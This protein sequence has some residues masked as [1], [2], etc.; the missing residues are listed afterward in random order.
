MMNNETDKSPWISLTTWKPVKICFL[1]EWKLQKWEWFSEL[2]YSNK[3]WYSFCQ[4]ESCFLCKLKWWNISEKKKFVLTAAYDYEKKKT[5]MIKLSYTQY[6]ELYQ[7]VVKKK[8][9][10]DEYV[11]E[12][13]NWPLVRDA[14]WNLEK[15]EYWEYFR[16]AWSWPRPR[17]RYVRKNELF[18]F[19]DFVITSNSDHWKT[20]YKIEILSEWNKRI[21]ERFPDKESIERWFESARLEKQFHEKVEKMKKDDEVIVRTLKWKADRLVKDLIEATL[22]KESENAEWDIAKQLEE[23]LSDMFE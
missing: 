7:A 8:E 1:K 5:R 9:E 6:N 13:R 18:T 15:N 11:D 3:F 10:L 14:D 22:L 21:C 12:Q 17:M 20:S 4:W 19:T 23:S 2:H 16:I